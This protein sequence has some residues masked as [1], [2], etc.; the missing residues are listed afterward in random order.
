PRPA[1][2]RPHARPGSSAR[3]GAARRPGPCAPRR[4]A[5]RPLVR[6]A[7]RGSARRRCG[8]ALLRP[9][10]RRDHAVLGVRGR[11][12]ARG[13]RARDDGL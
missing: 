8:R 5:A 3:A 4:P 11:G 6:A 13:H 2:R 10:R 1:A 12:V 9:R 7:G